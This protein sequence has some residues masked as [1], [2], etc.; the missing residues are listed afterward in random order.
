MP[1]TEP[2]STERPARTPTPT[3]SLR[4]PVP[5]PLAA[6]QGVNTVDSRDL[7]RGGA[8]LRIRHGDQVYRLQRT[9]LGKLIL[10][11]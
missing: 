10:T 8:E 4:Q 7:L 6:S 9:A 1:S 5:Q 2:D 3:P 11:K